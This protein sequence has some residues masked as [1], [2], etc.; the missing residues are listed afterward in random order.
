MTSSADLIT[1]VQDS[2]TG[3]GS[4]N[5][6]SIGKGFGK[7]DIGSAPLA[8]GSSTVTSNSSSGG[9]LVV[10][11]EV[12][13]TSGTLASF[14]ATMSGGAEAVL[15]VDGTS[16]FAALKVAEGTTVLQDGLTVAG[17]ATFSTP[18]A[19]SNLADIETDGK[20]KVEAVDIAGATSASSLAI[21]DSLLVRSSATSSNKRVGAT[22]L[23]PF[24]EA[25]IDT[26]AADTLTIG[27][28]TATTIARPA[29]TASQ[30]RRF[31]DSSAVSAK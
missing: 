3:V 9:A 23:V 28:D 31:S 12:T 15:K 27:G 22:A 18:L 21:G 30:S 10:Q 19:D 8:A 16:G 6:G 26:I 1:T 11:D 4:L 5:G 25:S 14:I 20:V 2:I 13:L 7:I 29:H 24:I 17:P